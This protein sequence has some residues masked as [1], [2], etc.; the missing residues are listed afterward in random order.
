M[1]MMKLLIENLKKDGIKKFLHEFLSKWMFTA[2]VVEFI[3]C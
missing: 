3:A 2:V 1:Y